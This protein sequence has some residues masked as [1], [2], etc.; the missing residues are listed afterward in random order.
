MAPT[1]KLEEE[2]RQN[3]KLIET[4]SNVKVCRDDTDDKFLNLAIDGEADVI[5]SRD[6]DLLILHPF[7]GIPILTPALF[8]AEFE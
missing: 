3:G 7:E 6:P 4:K 2:I 8:L 5:L 1:K